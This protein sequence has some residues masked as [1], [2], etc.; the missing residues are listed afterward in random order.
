MSGPV[1]VCISDT[2]FL[3]YPL[4]WV[5]PEAGSTGS[6]DYAQSAGGSCFY[7]VEEEVCAGLVL[8]PLSGVALDK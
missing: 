4:P 1:D 5:A 8:C 6:L 2:S 7:R 3:N